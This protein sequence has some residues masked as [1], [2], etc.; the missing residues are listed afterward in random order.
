MLVEEHRSLVR[1]SVN[2]TLVFM[3]ELFVES[4]EQQI[5]LLVIAHTETRVQSL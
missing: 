2:Q 4:L 3:V 1:W 5:E